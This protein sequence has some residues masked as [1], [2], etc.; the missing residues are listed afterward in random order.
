MMETMSAAI[1][2]LS[3]ILLNR[4]ELGLP[5]GRDPD[6]CCHPYGTPAYP[7]CALT[8][9]LFVLKAPPQDALIGLLVPVSLG[10]RTIH[11]Y[12]VWLAGFVP[13]CGLG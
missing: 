13:A 3:C 1:K 8:G 11:T 12:L 4:L 5:P 7:V 10:I 6:V 2:Y 9:S